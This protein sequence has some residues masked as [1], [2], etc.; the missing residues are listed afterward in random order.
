VAISPNGEHVAYVLS[1]PR[2][3]DD[4]V[5]RNYSEIYVM[6]A[7]GGQPRQFTSAPVSARAVAWSPDGNWLTFLSRRSDHSPYTQ[8]YMIPVDG[9]AARLLTSHTASVGRYA[10]APDGKSIA[11]ISRDAVSSEEKNSQQKWL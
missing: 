8:V 7:E 1:V 9:G 11:F 5:G 6:S 3:A 4:K 2:G 10:W